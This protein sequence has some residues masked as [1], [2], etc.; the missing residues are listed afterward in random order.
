WNL[1][2]AARPPPVDRVPEVLRGRLEPWRERRGV[3]RNRSARRR[4]IASDSEGDCG[5]QSGQRPGTLALSGGR[6]LADRV[7]ALEPRRGAES[8]EDLPRL[9]EQRLSLI[10]AARRDEP[11]SVFQQNDREVEARVDLS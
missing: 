4:S 7:E 3:A 9:G 8:S 1:S 11:L 2:D 5:E 10:G 6:G